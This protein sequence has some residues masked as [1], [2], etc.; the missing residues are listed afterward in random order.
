MPLAIP[1]AGPAHTRASSFITITEDCSEQARLTAR[2]P[3][4]T[5]A[6]QAGPCALPNKS[7]FRFKS[8]GLR[9]NNEEGDT[10]LLR[11]QHH[12]SPSSKG[13]SALPAR[14]PRIKSTPPALAW[15]WRQRLRARPHLCS[16]P[17][18]QPQGGRCRGRRGDSVAAP[19]TRHGPPRPQTRSQP[20]AGQATDIW[21]NLTSCC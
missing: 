10:R 7:S 1:P 15:Q 20:A 17:A 12:S 21:P 11:F 4:H 8:P 19:R 9:I 13:R 5:A 16:G 3:A 6:G 14:L 18:R 2:G